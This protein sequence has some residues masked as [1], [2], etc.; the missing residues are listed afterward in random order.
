MGGQHL[1]ERLHRCVPMH[2][3]VAPKGHP[4]LQGE[5]GPSGVHLVAREVAMEAASWNDP[6]GLQRP[7]LGGGGGGL[8]PA[9][10]PLP[11]QCPGNF[12]PL[13]PLRSGT[14][15]A[16]RPQLFTRMRSC[17]KASGSRVTTKPCS[18]CARWSIGQSEVQAAAASLA[19][20]HL[21]PN[22]ANAA[23]WNLPF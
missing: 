4:P 6:A 1:G 18:P 17:G 14:V 12:H 5:G 7:F 22:L 13:H 21:G 19:P 20:P 16:S 23:A 15:A 10:Q 11:A 2:P 8:W 3:H 9:S